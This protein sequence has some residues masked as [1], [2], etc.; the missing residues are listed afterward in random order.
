MKRIV[1]YEDEAPYR[2]QLAVLLNA[3]P[4]L[5]VVGAFG[6]CKNLLEQVSELYPDL[7]LLDIHMPGVDGLQGLSMLKAHF[8]DIPALML[9]VFDDDENIFNAIC[10]GADGYF[11]K[12]TPPER[13]TT[14]VRDFFT[15]GIP[16]SPAVA[17][18]VLQLFG[19]KGLKQKVDYHLTPIEH[20]V[21]SHLSN[22]MS[23]KMVAGA[24]SEPL[25]TVR[26]QIKSI[27]A[28]LG[29]HSASEAI[30]KAIREGIV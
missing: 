13:I 4:T 21:L 2:H 9:T 16:M 19:G 8:P 28:K 5:K 1:I 3:V 20:E 24:M 10:I 7:V 18:R 29:V 26:S 30:S 22:G 17:R 25:D 15:D 6:H 14:L 23:Y 12:N 11:L 27:Y